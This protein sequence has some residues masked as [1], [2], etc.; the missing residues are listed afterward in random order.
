MYG[1]IETLK[2]EFNFFYDIDRFRLLHALVCY[3][4]VPKFRTIVL[5][6][7]MQK[8]EKDKRKRICKKLLLKYNIDVGIN[9]EIG[10]H[11]RI[12]HYNGIV[13][14]D[15]V[16][17]GNNCT[18]YQGVTIGQRNGLYPM[19]GDNVVIYPNSIVLGKIRIE[20]NSVILAGSIVLNDVD[21]FAVVAGNPAITKKYLNVV[22]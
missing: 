16:K 19:I 20:N 4:R 1:F 13:I 2:E 10:K 3:Y 5:I 8:K 7:Y 11:L 17:L 12:E 14:G 22:K 21:E 9:S 18:I 15:G 6:Q